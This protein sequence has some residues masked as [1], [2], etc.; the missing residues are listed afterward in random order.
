MDLST[1]EATLERAIATLA[2]VGEVERRRALVIVNP[3]A[4][5]VSERLRS[6]V[7]Y[8]LAARYAV[9]AIETQRQGHATE[10]ARQASGERFDLV[11]ALGGDGTVNEAANG[12]VGTDVPLTCLPGGSANVYCKLLGIPGEIVDATEHLLRM[13]DRFA[14][15]RVAL[16]LVEDRHYLFSAGVGLDADVV[17][18]VDA[19]PALKRRFGPY[20]FV[21]VAMATLL[22]H[23]A[24][25]APRMFVA[26]GG[27]TLAGVTAI[28]QKGEH[29]TY[30]H[31]R[32][33]DLAEGA[34][35]DGGTLSGVVL[36][37]A[38]LAA[39]PSLATRAMLRRARVTRH[40][41]VS[42]FTDAAALTVSS[43]AGRS[44]PL[45]VDGDYIGQV[46][47]ARFHVRPA[48]LTVVA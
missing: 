2:P 17:R 19:H 41:Q 15:R 34:T 18:R 13:A 4:T 12:L 7:I 44:L 1:A 5:T 47:E 10:L 38:S 27:E 28:V 36:R 24:V 21:G 31:D 35:L 48:A 3:H 14:P 26:V 43:A 39:V 45:Q 22:R 20:F 46:T 30:F 25:G 8:A 37:R 6:L 23:Y 33:I 11:V 40:R 42:A 9:E 16:G 29:Y 32:P